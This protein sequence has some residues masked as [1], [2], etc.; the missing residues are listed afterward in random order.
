MAF[1]LLP[2][3]AAERDAVIQRAVVADLGGLTDDDAHAV[4]D[5]EPPPDA[6]GR[7][8]LDPVSQRA[9]ED[10]SRAIHLSPSPHS[11]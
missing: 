7:M 5:E 10:S 8:D 1:A 11:A 2:G 4:I 3:R 9:I 6:R